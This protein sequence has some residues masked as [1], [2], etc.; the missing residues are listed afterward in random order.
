[1]AFR[2]GIQVALGGVVV[3]S[4][5]MAQAD[6]PEEAQALAEFERLL[7]LQVVTASKDPRQIGEAPSIVSVLTARDIQLAGITTVGEALKRIPGFFGIDDFLGDNPGIRGINGGTRAYGRILKVMI[8]GQ[9]VAFRSDSTYQLGPELIPMEVVERIEVVRGPASALYGANAFLGVVNVITRN[10]GDNAVLVRG[11]RLLG[12]TGAGME[13]VAAWTGPKG[14]GWCAFGLLN[15][16]RSGHELP[17]TSS[18]FRTR[19]PAE[20]VSRGDEAKPRSLYA[21]AWWEPSRDLRL[22][23]NAHLSHLDA[24]AEWLDFGTLSHQNRVALSQGFGR[25]KADWRP[26]AVWSVTAF[27][28]FAKGQPAGEEHLFSG[29]TSS[30]PR[31]AFGYKA[32]DAGLEVRAR[33]LGGLDLVAGADWSEDQEQLINIY[34]VNRATGVAV[35]SSRPQGTLRFTN[36]GLYAQLQARPWKDLGLTANLR[37][38]HHG[39]YGSSTNLRLAAVSHLGPSVRAKLLFGTSFKAPAAQQLYA[40]PLFSGETVGNPDL[41]PEKARTL[42]AE[43]R[44]QATPRLELTANL[45]R[46][47]VTDKVELV[48]LG[49]DQQ[50]RNIGSQRSTGLEGEVNLVWGRHTCYANLSYQ[51]TDDVRKDPFYGELSA[52]STLYPGL[53]SV[54]R[55]RVRLPGRVQTEATLRQVGPR[56]ES[57]S[58]IERNYLTPYALGGYVL[59][60]VAAIKERGPH[61]LQAKV[62]N[63]LDRRT[64]EPGARGFD[65]PGLRR[66]WTL[67]YALSF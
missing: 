5:A 42:E 60:E 3:A 10:E 64:A 13:G 17:L 31:R 21:K 14:G 2:R 51:R 6:A 8:D 53:Q 36:T 39:I 16:D 45:F 46:N 66:Q 29:S 34:T 33:T 11:Q 44:W 41:R 12:H 15:Q 50:P 28:A 67:S 43:F 49:T 54:V 27:T 7:K 40:Q 1:M 26:D 55:W 35:L 20:V 30:Y 22:E 47:R 18:I 58:N 24:Q 52:P 59:A 37:W 23:W 32:W 25:L 63:L 62:Q 9:P 38:D 56:R 4:P 19:P 65:I 61:R 57:K 48:P